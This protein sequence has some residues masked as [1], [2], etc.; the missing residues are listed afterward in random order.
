MIRHPLLVG[1]LLL[2]AWWLLRGYVGALVAWA[3][4]TFWWMLP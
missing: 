3:Q 4:A 1:L 2:V